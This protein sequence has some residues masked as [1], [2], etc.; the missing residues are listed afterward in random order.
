MRRRLKLVTAFWKQASLFWC[1][2][3]MRHSIVAVMDWATRRVLPFRLSNTRAMPASAP[4]PSQTPWSATAAPRSSTPIRGSQFTSLEFPSV[5]K[6][7]GVAIS[8]D[9]TGRYMGN[10]FIGPPVARPLKYEAVY[11][12]ELSDGFQA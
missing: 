12:H 1:H 2:Y 4:I 3:I 10:I 9:R 5:L 8:M 7:S 11:L 6:D